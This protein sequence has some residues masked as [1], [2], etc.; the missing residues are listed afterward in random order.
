MDYALNLAI[1]NHR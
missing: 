1:D